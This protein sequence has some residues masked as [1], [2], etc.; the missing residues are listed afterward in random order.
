[1]AETIESGKGDRYRLSPKAY[2]SIDNTVVYA[3]RTGLDKLRY[4][5]SVLKLAKVQGYV[6]RG[7][8]AELLRITPPQA[9]RVLEYPVA[10]KKLRLEG[11]GRYAK[12]I[13]I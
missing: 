7:N 11:R 4:S 8:A 12:Y 1:L 3:R 2:R 5:E 6:A 9:Y 10:D 13:P